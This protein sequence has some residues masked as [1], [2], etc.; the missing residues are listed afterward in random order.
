MKKFYLLLIFSFLANNI[1]FVLSKNEHKKKTIFVD[2]N[3]ENEDITNVINSLSAKKE[4]NILLPQPAKIKGKITFNTKEE[5]TLDEAWNL[6]ITILDLSGYTIVNK[7]KFYEIEKNDTVVR[8]PL[9]LY[10]NDFKNIPGNDQKI[11]FIYFF[12]NL[13]VQ[14]TGSTSYTNLDQILKDMMSTE[15]EGNS[16]ILDP[17]SNSLTITGKAAVI[18]GI[19]QIIDELER[20]GFPESIDIIQ[21]MHTDSDF[22]S[23]IIT[24]LLP[25]QQEPQF[26]YGPLPP[27][28][29]KTGYFIS[30]QTK[31]V[32]I[33][34]TNSLAIL[35][36]PFS[37]QRVKNFIEKY[38]DVPLESEKSII[39]VKA[40]QYLDA[41]ALAPVISAVVK[42]KAQAA[43]AESATSEKDGLANAII[44]AEKLT[45]ASKIDPTK[46]LPSI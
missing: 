31:V 18:K 13:S 25:N 26:R 10:V 17:N 3:Y 11:R 9:E 22:V 38:I 39:H 14:D 19:M 36:P 30:D 8:E 20:A 41:E 45:P 44:W 16:Y 23:K 15:A 35:G 7:G 12:N 2:F 27:K 34:R 29:T 5:I 43:Q 33:A 24:Q 40:L 21:L 28:V 6:L 37:V 42:G 46:P 1:S 4:I 32:P